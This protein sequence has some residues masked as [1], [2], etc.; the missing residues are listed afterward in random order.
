MHPER[1]IR[2][3]HLTCAGHTPTDVRIYYKEVRSLAKRYP[4]IHIV[5]SGSGR[6]FRIGPVRFHTFRGRS[7]YYNLWATLLL[8]ARLK[9]QV[10]H[11][12]DAILNLV[13]F[14]LKWRFKAKIIYDI[15]E[16]TRAVEQT[17]QRGSRLKS[18]IRT[19]LILAAEPL[20]ASRVDGLVLVSPDF[21]TDYARLN[22]N[23]VYIYNF[24]DLSL[25]T[26][27]RQP[28]G[29]DP[30]V[31]IYQGHIAPERGILTMLEAVR[32]LTGRGVQV[33]F[34]LIGGWDPP[35]F[36]QEFEEHIE[37]WGLRHKVE[38]S[39]WV[40][41]RLMPEIMMSASVGIAALGQGP[42]FQQAWP[43]KPFEYMA[44]GLPIVGAETQPM[45][46]IFAESHCGTLL[47]HVTAETLATAIAELLADPARLRV[48]GENGIRAVRERYNWAAMERELLRFYQRI[49]GS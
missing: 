49:L 32:I 29:A 23:L 38:I 8:A 11:Y 41:H 3:C 19:R 43:N 5:A 26:H 7:W 44:A 10:Y 45:A 6:Q 21:E 1:P 17:F 25:F 36:R 27:P 28:G 39:A 9:A 14:Y 30:P 42:V 2:I 20:V 12:H 40:D 13:I 16:S 31:L 46:E 37:R 4:D 22:S 34:R 15:H 18:A 35:E 24:P 33:R 47:S 48:M